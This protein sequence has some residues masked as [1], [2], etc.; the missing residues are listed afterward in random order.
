MEKPKAAGKFP[1]RAEDT[2]PNALIQTHL[3]AGVSNWSEIMALVG[4][5][6]GDKRETIRPFESFRL[7]MRRM[8]VP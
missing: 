6:R 4:C 1:G 3:N 2:E 5:S 8:L 7:L